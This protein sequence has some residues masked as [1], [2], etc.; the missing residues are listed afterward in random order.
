MDF[1]PTVVEY[2]E[3]REPVRIPL[4]MSERLI[5]TRWERYRLVL[6]FKG[7]VSL[8][9]PWVI[10]AAVVLLAIGALIGHIF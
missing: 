5:P 3:N 8:G 9:T 10:G 7:G 1:E 4:S 2:G 6:R